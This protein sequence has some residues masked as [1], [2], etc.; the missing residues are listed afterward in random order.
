MSR[1]PLYAHTDLP[2]GKS[3]TKQD[4]AMTPADHFRAFIA[5]KPLPE[6]R[7]PVYA[8]ISNLNL[9][10]TRDLVAEFESEFQSLPAHVRDN[11]ENDSANY[12]DFLE[13]NEAEVNSGG[14]K[15]LLEAR[16]N[17]EENATESDDLSQN[18]PE[19]AQ[20]GA[21]EPDAGTD[22]TS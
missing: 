17:P 9:H 4:G 8:D 11:F 18:A 2:A 21:T 20:N 7:P 14:L 5:G 16:L 3:L 22:Q 10:E 6:G 1:K 12:L 15:G 13:E 19:G